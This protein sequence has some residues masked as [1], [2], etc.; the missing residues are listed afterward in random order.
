M[1]REGLSAVALRCACLCTSAACMAPPCPPP[2]SQAAAQPRAESP[3]GYNLDAAAEETQRRA[4]LPQPQACPPVTRAALTNFTT[5]S[6]FS[7]SVIFGD[8]QTTLSGGIFAYP[9]NGSSYPIRSDLAEGDWHL[10]G[11]I[12]D[13]SGFGLFWYLCHKVDASAFRGLSFSV[14]GKVA[15]DGFITLSINTAANE[16]SPEWLTSRGETPLQAS[17]GRCIPSQNRYDG[18]CLA[19][20]VQI[21]VTDEPRVHE[22]LWEQL[23][24]GKPEP[25]INPAEI[26]GLSW[27]FPAPAGVSTALREPYEVDIRLDD[28]AFIPR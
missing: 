16:I 10:T 2:A 25:S 22:V 9:T 20:M 12:G 26:T 19:A 4:A 23:S 14:R 21:P 24:G 13:Y 17:F 3:P 1:P 11:T 5:P 7:N 6:G 8:S 18:S 15:R 28:L 27:M